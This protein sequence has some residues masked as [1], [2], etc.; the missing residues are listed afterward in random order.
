MKKVIKIVLFSLLGLIATAYLF[1]LFSYNGYKPAEVQHEI[2]PEALDYFNK[3]Y[4]DCRSAFIEKA[5]L[6]VSQYEEVDVFNIPVLSE[7]DPDL[8]IDFCYIP[9]QNI[10][11]NLLILSS[12]VHGI[13]GFTSSAVQLMVMEEILSP[14]RLEN[15]G[16]LL[17]HGVNPY[18][19]KHLRRVTENNIDMNRNCAIDEDLFNIKNEGYA[20]LF[21]ML[22]P[23]GEANHHSLKNRHMHLV[24]IR[25][26]LAESMPVLRQAVLQGQ[27]EYSGGLFFGGKKLEQQIVDITPI[28]QE[29]ITPYARILTIDLHT[30]YGENGAM[31]LFPNPI[32]DLGKKANMEEFFAGYSIDWGNRGGFYTFMGSFA[33]YIGSLAPGKTYFPMVFEFGTLDS[34]KTFGSIRSLQNLILENQGFHHGYKNEKT[35]AKIKENFLE[36]FFPSNKAWRS[37][38]I[39][40][41]KKIIKLVFERF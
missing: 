10:S 5:N 13:E 40:D 31:H 28:L 18:G 20:K 30:G 23:K 26:I 2:V 33:D 12:G 11:D 16:I 7:I 25:K 4:E 32:K 35:E 15:V 41:S 17:I 14:N 1:L 39:T 19:F 38:V 24:A 27:Y 36:A 3:T 9:A 6:L 37:K 21:D 8:T 29:K 34:Q 22:N